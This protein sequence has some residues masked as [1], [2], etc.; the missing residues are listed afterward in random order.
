MEGIVG[1]GDEIGVLVE[2]G[3]GEGVEV[4]T[5]APVLLVLRVQVPQPGNSNIK[6]AR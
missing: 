2:L 3:V 4:G 6:V 5:I 1:V